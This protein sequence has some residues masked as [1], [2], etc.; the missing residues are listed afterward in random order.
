MTS[1][2]RMGELSRKYHVKATEITGRFIIV[3][4]K[5]RGELGTQSVPSRPSEKIP[6]SARCP[7]NPPQTGS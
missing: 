1:T 5:P 4:E 6:S 2:D 3:G 7:K